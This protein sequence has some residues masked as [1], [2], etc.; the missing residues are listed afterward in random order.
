MRTGGGRDLSAG[1][2]SDLARSSSDGGA[3]SDLAAAAP[4]LASARDLASQPSEDAGIWED[5]ASG[6]W[7]DLA[8]RSDLVTRDMQSPAS[9][10]GAPKDLAA[11]PDAMAAA[12]KKWLGDEDGDGITD[13]C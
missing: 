13:Q 1:A 3:E 8:A 7:V 2:P 9:D 11:P 12:C 4:D 10:L 6:W 5:D